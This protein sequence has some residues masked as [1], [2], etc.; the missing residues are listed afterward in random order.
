MTRHS[1]PP[2]PLLPLRSSLS[3][4]FYLSLHPPTPTPPLPPFHCFMLRGCHSS[5]KEQMDGGKHSA[6][7]LWRALRFALYARGKHLNLEFSLDFQLNRRGSRFALSLLWWD[8]KHICFGDAYRK[9]F[10]SHR[11][12]L[13]VSFVF[14]LKRVSRRRFL[15]G[16]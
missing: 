14:V 1:P 12:L 8:Y 2:P 5:I 6:R 11:S 15:I 16:Q 9:M 13:T 10:P 4:L 7:L 3:F